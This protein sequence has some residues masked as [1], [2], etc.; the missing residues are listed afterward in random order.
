MELKQVILY[1]DRCGKRHVVNGSV[2]DEFIDCPCGYSFYLFYSEGMTVKM[3]AREMMTDENMQN[4]RWFVTRT[5]R[6]EKV[7]AEPPGYGKA[8]VEIYPPV[9]IEMGLRR[10]QEKEYEKCSMNSGDIDTI[11]SILNQDADVLVKNKKGYVD[12]IE[13]QNKPRETRT[14]AAVEVS[15]YLE[16]D[17]TVQSRQKESMERNRKGR[18]GILQD[19]R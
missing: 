13:L 19:T 11:L 6:C 14:S 17:P 3:P 9:L 18:K 7:H 10:L 5:G 4:F 15:K 2:I 1:C 16:E 8:L 12:V